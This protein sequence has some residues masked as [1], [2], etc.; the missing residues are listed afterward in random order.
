MTILEFPSVGK[1]GT[2]RTQPLLGVRPT[3][4]RAENTLE[5]TS[6][7]QT[8]FAAQCYWV[9]LFSTQVLQLCRKRSLCSGGLRWPLQRPVHTTDVGDAVEHA[10]PISGTRSTIAEPMDHGTACAARAKSWMP[11]TGQQ[12]ASGG[13]AMLCDTVYLQLTMDPHPQRHFWAESLYQRDRKTLDTVWT[14][15]MLQDVCPMNP[16]GTE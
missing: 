16:A 1:A 11:S 13:G 7:A 12:T 14:M 6:K 2:G 9:R 8:S 5:P 10:L 4:N 15:Q 3:K